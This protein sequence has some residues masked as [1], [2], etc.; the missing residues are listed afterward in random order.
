MQPMNLERNREL[1]FL[2]VQDGLDP[3]DKRTVY[4]LILND[5]AFR[6]YLQE[7]VKLRERMKRLRPA[8]DP[9]LK[10]RLLTEIKTRATEETA[11]EQ[12]A[13]V[14]NSAVPRGIEQRVAEGVTEQRLAE[15]SIAVQSA[16][17]ETVVES[18]AVNIS[19]VKG[20][21][22]ATEPEWL[23]WSEW[24]LKMLTPPLVFPL[25]KYLQRR[26]FA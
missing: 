22:V 17:E 5:E 11:A 4:E 2:Y 3:E 21:T 6:R 10:N 15:H 18:P 26:C 25:I 1:A 12:R 24:V 19:P 23:R 7:E 13:A 14:Q 20:S 9:A 16:A 8:M